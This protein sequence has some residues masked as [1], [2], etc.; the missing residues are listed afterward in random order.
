[1]GRG[2]VAVLVLQRRSAAAQAPHRTIVANDLD[3]MEEESMPSALVWLS[4]AVLAGACTGSGSSTSAGDDARAGVGSPIPQPVLPG[5]IPVAPDAQR[6]DL[7]VPAFSHPTEITNPLFPVSAQASVLFV[8]HVDGKP[9]RTEVTLLPYT[10][11]IE[12]GGQ[13]IQTLVSQYVAYLDGRLQEVAYDLYA[14]ADDGSV[15]YFGEDVADLAHGDIVTK[16]GTWTAGKDGPGQ[17]IMPGDPK[18]GEVFRTENIPGIA[19]E[20]VTVESVDRTLPGPV[21]PIP[22]GMVGQELHMDG[23]TEYKLFAPG[24]GEFFTRDGKDVEA[25]ATAVPT[26]AVSGG[27]PPELTT[28]EAGAAQVADA[29]ASGHWSSA[30]NIVATMDAAWRSFR[31]GQ[32]PRLE[33]PWMAR[34]MSALQTD[35]RAK[36]ELRT[37][38]ASIDAQQRILDL[39]LRYRPSVQINLARFGLWTDQL[40]VDA[41]A[42]DAVNVNGDVFTLFYMRDRLLGLFTPDQLSAVNTLID[43]L[44]IAGADRDLAGA[45]SAAAKLHDVVAGIE[46]SNG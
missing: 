11:V 32:V 4:I 18:P 21:G 10:R 3:R 35:V 29:A 24:Y 28:L 6:V 7:T 34:A 33:V 26:D 19:F 27:T 43:R 14:Q 8:G 41:A 17:M 45:S 22:G 15:W 38:Q 39:E 25:L 12:W 37:R 23:K 42:H 9:F 5:N 44:Q 31:G 30:S 40:L 2:A 46:A 20:Q 36:D 13:S 1:V 16:E